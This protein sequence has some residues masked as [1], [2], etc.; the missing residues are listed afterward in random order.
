M[1]IL[2]QCTNENCHKGRLGS[3]QEAHA[4]D[5]TCSSCHGQALHNATSPDYDLCEDNDET[6]PGYCFRC[7]P[8]D[9][10]KYV[11]NDDDNEDINDDVN[12]D[13]NDDVN[14][15]INEDINETN[16]Y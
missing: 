12:E 6:Y 7:C 1:S 9:C 10:S 8:E 16:S 3:V 2:C 11:L 14:E 15:D 5:C 13:V 4:S